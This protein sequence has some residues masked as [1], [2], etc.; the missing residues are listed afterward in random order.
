V[1]PLPAAGAAALLLQTA[2]RIVA[3]VGTVTRALL[4]LVRDND[5]DR[6]LAGRI[7]QA[8]VAGLDINVPRSRC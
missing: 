3:E 5:N 6:D 2:G 4:E 8:C 7:C 1:A